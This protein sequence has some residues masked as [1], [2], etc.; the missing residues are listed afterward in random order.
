M[1]LTAWSGTERMVGQCSYRRMALVLAILILSVGCRGIGDHASR[2][3]EQAARLL[4]ESA[5]GSDDFDPCYVDPVGRLYE[6]GEPPCQGGHIVRLYL[7]GG[8]LT[9]LG[10]EI[11]VLGHLEQLNMSRNLLTGLPPELGQLSELEYLH[12]SYN[13]LPSLP[14]EI[15]HLRSLRVLDLAGNSLT[16]LPPEIGQL[17]ALEYLYLSDNQLTSLPPEL[18][19]LEDLEGLELSGNLLSALPPMIEQLTQLRFLDVS[20]NPLGGPLPGYLADLSQVQQFDFSGTSLCLPD[21]ARLQA[22]YAGVEDVSSYSW[23]IACSLAEGE[24]AALLA[25]YE[26]VGQARGWTMGEHPCTWSEVTC[27][28]TGHVVWLNLSHTQLAELPPQIGSF[29]HLQQLW[30]TENRLTELPPEIGQLHGLRALHLDGNRLTELPPEIGRLGQLGVL[31]LGSNELTS[32]PPEIGQLTE[33]SMLDVSGNPLSGPLPQYL[34]DLSRAHF[35]FEQ[36][37]L[38]IPDDETFWAWLVANQPPVHVYVPGA[39]L[40]QQSPDLTVDWL[41]E[42]RVCED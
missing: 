38:C 17:G 16:S 26:V 31:Y 33:L 10:P 39:G 7:L 3:E 12:L 19:R 4:Y 8:H 27:D 36:T 11:G 20:D 37:D 18:G 34:T 25:L 41:R 5:H 21:D 2:D 9:E 42:H 30:L 32:L 35:I 28:W 15:G 29:D 14:T 23:E 13:Q 6:L 24:R 40:E 1:N 22:W